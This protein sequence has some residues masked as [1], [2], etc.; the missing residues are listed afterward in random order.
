MSHGHL[1][2]QHQQLL[3]QLLN[4]QQHFH[5]QA[6]PPAPLKSF[7]DGQKGS[8]NE[9][10]SNNKSQITPIVVPHFSFAT[11]NCDESI[12]MTKNLCEMKVSSLRQELKLRR[13]PVSGTKAKL[14]ERLLL[15]QGCLDGGSPPGVSEGASPKPAS[16]ISP[17]RSEPSG[18]SCDEGEPDEQLREKE[19]QIEELTRRLQLERHRVEELRKQ[20]ERV[21]SRDQ[22]WV[23]IRAHRRGGAVYGRCTEQF[24]SHATRGDKTGG[25]C[26]KR[27]PRT[28]RGTIRHPDPAACLFHHS[29]AAG[30]RLQPAGVFPACSA[31]SSGW[32][33]SLSQSRAN[34]TQIFPNGSQERGTHSIASLHHAVPNG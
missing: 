16:S 20:L 12:G 19:R 15:F 8:I 1:L 23:G 34:G 21:E 17:S 2:P 13:L 10:D 4:Q 29:T 28:T 18:P 27:S 9:T 31:S 24:G 3:I 5:Y 6:I 14:I 25:S 7:A 26:L 11:K 33:L 22:R 30:Q 32:G